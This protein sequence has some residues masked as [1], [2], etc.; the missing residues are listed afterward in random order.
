MAQIDAGNQFMS[1]SA[2]ADGK[3]KASFQTEGINAFQKDRK[4]CVVGVLSS[5]KSAAGSSKASSHVAVLSDA[6]K[7][8]LK[9][10]AGH[11]EEPRQQQST[12]CNLD[13]T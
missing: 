2:L 11:R 4:P 9:F 3:C 8:R 6:D 13:P 1:L 7:H 10:Q 5:S 12:T